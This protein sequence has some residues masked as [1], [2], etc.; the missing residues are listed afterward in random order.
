MVVVKFKRRIRQSG[1]SAAIVIPPEI[2]RALKWKLGDIV[3]LYSEDQ[4]LVV[5]KA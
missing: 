1:G 2:L 3:E 5:K 4:K